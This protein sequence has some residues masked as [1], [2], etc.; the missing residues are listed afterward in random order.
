MIT[1]THKKRVSIHIELEAEGTPEMFCRLWEIR[2]FICPPITT[3][4]IGLLACT[5]RKILITLIQLQSRIKWE[6]WT[7]IL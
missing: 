4:F 1:C 5:L 2:K 7:D 3:N 6:Y